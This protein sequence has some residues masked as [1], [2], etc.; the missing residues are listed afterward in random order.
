MKDE[1]ARKHESQKRSKACQVESEGAAGKF[2]VLPRE[3][4]SAP[5][6]FAFGVPS[7][8]SQAE[9]QNRPCAGGEFGVNLPDTMKNRIRFM[10]VLGCVLICNSR[11]AAQT[12]LLHYTF[13][14]ASGDAVDAGVAPSAPGQ[15]LGGAARSADTPSGE[16]FAVDFT[17][18]EP[19][20]HVLAG[21][22][23][24]L[25][26]LTQ[27]TLTT[28]LKV[29]SYSSGNVRLM[30]K[31]AAGAFGG[32]SWNMNATPN[33][34]DVG[35][36]NFRL[37]L[38]LGN[39]ISSGGSDFAFGYSTADV[40]TAAD[41]WVFLAVT[42]DGLAETD[43]LQYFIGG[44]DRPVEP[45]G[46]TQSMI[47]LTID[48]GDSR[49]GV[50]FTDAAP[51]ANT[52]VIGQQDD[53]RVYGSVLTIE[54]LNEIRTGGTPGGPRLEIAHSGEQVMISWPATASDFALETATGLALGASWL[55][56]SDGI[57]TVGD[58]FVLTV[59]PASAAAF[60]R[61]RKP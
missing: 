22:T 47:A 28:W 42:Y 44:A 41:N 57:E 36:D 54:E 6:P 52:S 21:D 46:E 31:Q 37:G 53:V 51:A 7:Q 33:D 16:G 19:Y 49:F 32:F 39:N 4:S 25:D 60:Y 30:S 48:G 14:E 34:G 11:A 8:A 58:R 38:F 59:N 1:C 15:L 5:L 23:D 55:P 20:A 61:L 50:G 13:D 43:N 56:L 29:A 45:L 2:G 18:E 17:T 27:I 35:P 40:E 26:G 10:W 3:T 9:K 24:K 12:P